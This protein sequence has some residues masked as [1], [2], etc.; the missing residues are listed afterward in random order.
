V[1]SLYGAK[2]SPSAEDLRDLDVLV[3]DLQ[4]AGVRFYTYSSTMLLAMESAREAGRTLVILDRPNPLGGERVE[5]PLSD[6]ADVVPRTLL[7]R[8]PGPLVH[9]L[10]LGEMARFAAFAEGREPPVVIGMEGWRRSLVGEDAFG[11][12][13]PPSPNLRSVE[14]ALAYP[15]TCLVEATNVSEGRGSDAPFL[16]IGAPWLD[17]ERLIAAVG[18]AA[19]RYGFSLAP[20]AFTPRAGPSA[21]SPKFE[22]QACRAVRVGVVDARGSRPYVFGVALLGALRGQPGFA[23]R[24]DGAALDRLVGSRALR[25]GL[26]AGKT[27]EEIAATDDAAIAE[28]RRRRTPALLY[29]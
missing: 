5:G 28:Y 19:V 29:R 10:T 12:W 1:V 26:D 22:G 3:V 20:T 8:A 18:P 15:G 17:P 2:Q 11:A 14:A 16:L 27:A 23:W 7:N 4:D 6:P 13:I 25:R 24:E 21:L 9:G